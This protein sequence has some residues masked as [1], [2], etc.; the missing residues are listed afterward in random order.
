MQPHPWSILRST[1]GDEGFASP[2]T[3]MGTMPP[4]LKWVGSGWGQSQTK[5]HSA[6]ERRECCRDVL[7]KYPGAKIIN[8]KFLFNKKI[9]YR[10]QVC[11]DFI[12][13]CWSSWRILLPKLHLFFPHRSG[14]STALEID[15]TNFGSWEAAVQRLEV[16]RK[17]GW[18]GK[19]GWNMTGNFCQKTRED[20]PVK[21]DE[22]DIYSLFVFIYIYILTQRMAKL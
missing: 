13:F 5:A 17:K 18:S 16:R 7:N 3:T 11:V 21:D 1:A 22:Y 8:P 14:W 12:Y 2:S 9:H 15:M 20:E 19:V 6:R 10:L 4:V